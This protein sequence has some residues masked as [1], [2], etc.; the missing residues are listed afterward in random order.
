MLGCDE[1]GFAD[2]QATALNAAIS[3]SIFAV[4]EA[5][6]VMTIA[7]PF[8]LNTGVRHCPRH[9]SLTA[10]PRDLVSEFALCSQRP[11][12]LG[13]CG[14]GVCGMEMLGTVTCGKLGNLSKIPGGSSAWPRTAL[15]QVG[16][17]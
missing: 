6:F 17:A 8:Q 10:V 15:E 13:M 2:I 7:L 14:S 1:A 9:Q 5:C 4:P 12:G 16:R 3:G 11:N